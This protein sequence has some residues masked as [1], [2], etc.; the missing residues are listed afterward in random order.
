MGGSLGVESA[1]ELGKPQASLAHRLRPMKQETEKFSYVR[2]Q[3]KFFC[4]LFR[5]A[6]CFREHCIIL[7]MVCLIGDM[8]FLHFHFIMKSNMRRRN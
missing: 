5:T 1:V 7:Y 3:R 8:D 4:L 6:H 2:A